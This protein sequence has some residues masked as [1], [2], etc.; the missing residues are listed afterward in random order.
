M[1][2]GADEP[3]DGYLK[4]EMMTL[5]DLVEKKKIKQKIDLLKID[6]EGADPLA[7]QGANK[8]LSGGQIRM[9]IFENHNIGA[10]QHTSLLNVI[11]SLNN[12]SFICNLIGKTGMV[13]LTD[14]WSP[15]YDFRSWSNVLCVHRHEKHLQYFIDQLFIINM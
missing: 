12:K 6:T 15:V 3:H 9:L 13:R 5:D 2:A 4:V 7:L 1:L 8:L 14:C 10:W 11:E